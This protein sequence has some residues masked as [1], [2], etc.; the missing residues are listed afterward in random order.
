MTNL[1]NRSI[2]ASAALIAS[3]LS[4]TVAVAPLRAE[5]IKVAVAY[6]DL[7][8]R[9][10]AGAA[11]LNARIARAA[12]QVCGQDDLGTRLQAAACRSQALKG[13]HAQL[14]AKS[15][16]SDAKLASR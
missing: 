1:K 9:S 6:G 11:I 13:A 14:A 4:M 2:A 10:D 5:P 3:I 7:D 15:A 8:I 12:R 16:S